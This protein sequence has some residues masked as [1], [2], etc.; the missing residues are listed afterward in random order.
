M[1][2]RPPHATINQRAKLVH[3]RMGSI[4]LGAEGLVNEPSEMM[5]SLGSL[6]AT[7]MSTVGSVRRSVRPRF[8]EHFVS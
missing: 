3:E 6:I 2:R 4:D 5:T 1:D 8:A 7:L